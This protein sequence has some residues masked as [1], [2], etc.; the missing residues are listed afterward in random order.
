VTVSFVSHKKKYKTTVLSKKASNGPAPGR[1][2]PFSG[3][4][5]T[6]AHNDAGGICATR[7]IARNNQTSER[8]THFAPGAS[9]IRGCMM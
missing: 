5:M 7:I 4:G 9:L 3:W 1:L 8:A 6:L 2:V